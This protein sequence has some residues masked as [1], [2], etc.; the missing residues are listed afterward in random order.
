[1]LV[2]ISAGE[3]RPWTVLPYS[4]EGTNTFSNK[5]LQSALKWLRR[6]AAEHKRCQIPAETPLPTRVIDV[7]G[8]AW[9]TVR[10]YETQNEHAEYLTLSHCWGGIQPLTTTQ[11]TLS[12]R[13]KGIRLE[14]MP[15]TFRDAVL[16]VRRLKKRY[17][18]IDSL[19]IVQ[20]NAADWTREAAK[21][22]EIYQGS[23]LTLA[24][25][26]ASND[27]EGCFSSSSVEVNPVVD[28]KRYRVYVQRPQSHLD[29]TTG[30]SCDLF[31]LT[32][33]AWIYQERLLSPRVLYF[34]HN[35]LMWECQEASTCEC[36]AVEMRPAVD[37]EEDSEEG[38]NSH[39][40]S[41]KMAHS[42]TLT[43][44]ATVEE[45]QIRWYHIVQEY[46][47]LELTRPSDKLPAIQGVAR[48]MNA[49]RKD[50]CLAGM[51]RNTLLDDLMWFVDNGGIR[52]E[53]RAPS[54]SWASM[55][56]EIRFI[57]G[58]ASKGE[59]QCEVSV[60]EYLGRNPDEQADSF[61]AFTTNRYTLVASGQVLPA[62]E[63]VNL[64]ELLGEHFWSTPKTWHQ[65]VTTVPGSGSVNF[66][67]KIG[68][69][70]PVCYHR[71]APPASEITPYDTYTAQ[72]DIYCLNL[73][74]D[75]LDNV[76]K[77][78]IMVLT[79][80]DEIKRTYKRM[81]LAALAWIK[82]REDSP[83]F[84]VEPTTITVI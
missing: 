69:F 73:A 49:F 23:W 8:H 51:W 47:A 71:D 13:K 2:L 59:A 34:G 81:G 32:R 53:E 11:R 21:M 9:S 84:G 43:P 76:L 17:L 27:L 7:G 10:L 45:L 3:P 77:H 42:K 56:G 4:A 48:H 33:R 72:S 36:S 6:C 41:L 55:D 44:T 52:H 15:K 83:F 75:S 22:A 62:T 19:C 16:F 67:V 54:W 74:T 5:S 30:Q 78:H 12:Q 65:S 18:W 37:S 28:G 82:T 35:E 50:D 24:A 57:R 46:S 80:V 79:V 66:A 58:N 20:D 31:P 39:L 60:A 14:S 1:M 26:K 38:R 68:S 25:L 64:Q 63:M 29:G 70:E 40:D 61:A